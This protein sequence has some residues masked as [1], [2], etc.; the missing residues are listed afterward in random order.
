MTVRVGYRPPDT[1]VEVTNPSGTHRADTVGSGYGLIGLR[2]RVTALGGEV[3]A[4]PAGAGAWR[5]A[6]RI[7]HP[8]GN[9]ENGARS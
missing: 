1:V 8:T 7:H 4:G 9:A 6:A 3:T 2:E 5:L